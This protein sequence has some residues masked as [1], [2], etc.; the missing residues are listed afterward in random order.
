MSSASIFLGV[1]VALVTLFDADGEVDHAA[2]ADH[3]ERLVAA[4]MRAVVVAGSTGEAAA[5]TRHERSELVSAVRDRIDPVIPVVAGTGAASARQAAEL[6]A[7]AVGAG[8]EAV[9]AL[10]PLRAAD[11]SRYYESVRV[12]AGSTPVLGYHFPAMSPPGIPVDVLATLPVDGVKDSS[13]DAGRL[14]ETVETYDGAVYVGSTALIV[15]AGAIGCAGAILAA[16]N[17]EPEDCVAAFQGDGLAQRRLLAAH[18]TSGRHFPHGLKEAL[19]EAFGT[20]PI[21]RMG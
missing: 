16:A 17:L 6:T 2:T 1:G 21:T 3:A 15:Q 7:D 11:P 19:A 18:Q 10:S 4:G 9:L 8:A 12:A 14:L 20:S 13:G 5:L